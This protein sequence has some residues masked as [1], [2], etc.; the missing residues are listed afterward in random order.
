MTIDLTPI[1][2]AVI[3]LLAAL[4]TY[5]LIPWIKSKTTEQ[6][7]AN[8]YAAARIAVFAAEQLFGAGQGQEKLE[9]AMEALQRAGYNVD[10]ELV[11][12]T[13]E[14]IVNSFT[15]YA[16]PDSMI[17]EDEP[18]DNEQIHPPETDGETD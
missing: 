7:Q 6:Q 11:R 2:Q 12:E 17:E 14:E 10:T 18:E 4:I 8:L 15:R 5:K 3:A 1:F 16:V 13:I 9:Y